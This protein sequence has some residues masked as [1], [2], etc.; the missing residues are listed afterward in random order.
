MSSLDNTSNFFSRN[1]TLITIAAAVA[2]I[3]AV[4]AL[5][6]LNAQQ[7]LPETGSADEASKKKKKNKK[8]KSKSEE[9]TASSATDSSAKIYPITK[10]GLPDITDEIVSKL[11]TADKEKW[12]LALKEDGNA[13]FKSKNYIPAIAYYTAALKLKIDPV[14]YSNRSACYAALD[15]HENVIKDTTEAIKLKPDY[16]KCVLRRATSYEI[17]ENYTDAMF[18]LT[19]LTIYGG[20][21][22]K[23]VEQ[24]LERV[25]KKHSV[26]IVEQNM[27]NRT[28]DLPS[29][30]TIGS[31]FGAFVTETNPEGISE[32]S[33]GTDKL[34][35]DAIAK[36]NLNTPEGYEQADKLMAEAVAGYE[37]DTLTAESEN[38]AKASIALEYSATFTFLKNDP[39]QAAEDI[40]KAVELK[41]RSR[42]Y[43]IRALINADRASYVEALA[44]FDTAAK[45]NPEAGDAYYHL[46]QLFYLTGDLAKAQENFEKAKKFNPQNVYAYVQSACITYKNGDIKDAEDK[47]TE[48]KLKFPTSP[49]IPNYYGEVLSDRGDTQAALKQFETA[50]RL[51][52]ALPNYSVGALP[53][54]NQASLISRESY[55]KLD[56]AEALLVEACDLDPKSELAR[57][58]LAQ[59][60]L[61]KEEVDDAIELFEESSNLARTIEEKVQATSFAEATKMQKRIKSDPI[62][63]EKIAE[64]MRQSMM[65]A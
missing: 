64:V 39:L 29:A 10:D 24:V 16:T 9:P 38:A 1:K 54:I 2:G 8:K 48:A 22:N 32:E 52:K 28:L 63:A 61:Q 33:T 41:P 56:D 58:S 49:E 43:V 25:L 40:R 12:A 55:D 6:F 14:F 30:S 35:F 53:L 59:L 19:A 4:S 47:F 5:Y 50:A 60:K 27:K 44:D 15:D 45:L 36:I 34:L 26:K 11:S 21:N 7:S 65:N 62:L 46:G 20:F 37:V 31:F 13:E 17:L 57:I 3:S 18:D 51:Q 42:T 23:S